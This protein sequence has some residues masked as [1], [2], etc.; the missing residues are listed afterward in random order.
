MNKKFILPIT[1]ILLIGCL[2]AGIVYIFQLDK[3]ITSRFEGRRWE[4]PA[5]IFA[6][7]LEL[8][9]GRSLSGV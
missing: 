4:L 5:R 7:P 6:R 8:Y 2:A 9:I 3:R 1:I